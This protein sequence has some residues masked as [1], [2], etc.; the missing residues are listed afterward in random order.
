MI[1]EYDDME[2]GE[3]NNI[4]RSHFDQDLYTSY[5]EDVMAYL[6]DDY[7]DMPTNMRKYGAII[8]K[9]IKRDA[10]REWKESRLSKLS[11]YITEG[12]SYKKRKLEYQILQRVQYCLAEG[13][14]YSSD[15]IAIALQF[16]YIQ[17]S[18]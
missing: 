12:P 1:Y 18:T 16:K 4:W 3:K 9:T 7:A 13:I 6:F 2:I 10:V 8:T 15:S 14:P 11:S 5:P 17:K